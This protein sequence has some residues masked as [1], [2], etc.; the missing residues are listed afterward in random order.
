MDTVRKATRSNRL[1]RD[2]WLSLCEKVDCGDLE[3]LIEGAEK[4]TR[5]GGN[6]SVAG[7]CQALPESRHVN[8]NQGRS[9]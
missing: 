3:K 5:R 4:I 7:V 6:K 8:V 2:L 9:C 1:W